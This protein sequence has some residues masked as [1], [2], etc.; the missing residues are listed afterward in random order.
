MSKYLVKYV[1][2]AALRDKLIMTLALMMLMVAAVAAFMGSTAVTEQDHSSLVFSA[3]ALRFLGVTGL[4]LFCCFYISR[5]FEN[6]E[7]EFLLSRPISRLSFLFS[8]AVAFM[9]L[10]FFTALAIMLVMMIIGRPDMSGLLVWGA[11]LAVE[12]SI[13]S[14]AALFFSMVL[15]SAAGSA[16]ATMGFYVLSRVIGTLFTIM[17]L[18]PA[19]WFFAFMNSIMELISILIPRLDLMGQTMWLVYGVGD[20][21]GIKFL[22]AAGSYAYWLIGHLGLIGFIGIQGILSIGLLLMAASYDFLR[23]QF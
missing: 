13:M 1:L 3:G 12:F 4:I 6:K 8:H 10:S 15:P 20:S 21:V 14:V 18:P 7:V 17:A 23:R 5:S 16:L 2:T 11:S 22:P 19:N 9:I